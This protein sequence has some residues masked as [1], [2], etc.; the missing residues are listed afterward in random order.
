MSI[1][2]PVTVNDTLPVR[3][4]PTAAVGAGWVCNIAAQ[5]VS[6]TRADALN[7]EASYPAIT[8]TVNVAPA[9][10]RS[11][12]NTAHVS[13]GGEINTANNTASDITTISGPEPT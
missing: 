9:A 10:P 1:S 12:T 3:L 6:C 11:L 2:G 4:T 13:G 7:A 8:L 5:V